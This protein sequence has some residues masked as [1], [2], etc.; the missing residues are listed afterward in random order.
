MKEVKRHLPILN[1][2]KTS[3]HDKIIS[4]TLIKFEKKNVN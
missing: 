2:L 4:N 3:L 1:N